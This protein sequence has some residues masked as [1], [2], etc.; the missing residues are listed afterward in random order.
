MVIIMK[1]ILFLVM[2]AA[3][4]LG[5][6]LFASCNKNKGDV[7]NVTTTEGGGD[8]GE[9]PALPDTVIEAEELLKYA[10][11]R[12]DDAT[13]SEKI[14][15]NSFVEELKETIGA[16]I[17]SKSDFLFPGEPASEFEI[18]FGETIREES[19]EAY[20]DIKY[21]DYVIAVKGSKIVI[22][23][24]SDE[25]L[26]EASYKFLSFINGGKLTIPASSY[27]YKAEYKYPEMKLD[28]VPV[29]EYD[30]IYAGTKNME[31]ANLIRKTIGNVSG[32]R[33]DLLAH[34][35]NEQTDREIVVGDTNRYKYGDM[36]FCSY[37]VFTN[38]K[39]IYLG[40][41]DYYAIKEA[42]YVMAEK[43]ETVG[44]EISLEDVCVSYELPKY[45]E[46]IEDIDKLYM[47]WGRE[48]QPDPA[49][50]DYNAKLDAFRNVSNRLLTCAHRA[51]C[52]YYPE[53]SIESIISF[54]KMGGDVVELDIQAT[55][56]G[57]LILMHDS[58]L[59]RMTNCEDFMG[60]TL[61]GID[62]PETNAVSDW[63]YEQIQYLNLKDGAG[64]STAVTPFKVPT[65]TEALKVC[66][67]RLLIIPDKTNCWSY[68]PDNSGK[69]DL[70]SCMKE[71][72][73]YESIIISYGLNDYPSGAMDIQKYIYDASGVRPFMLV[74]SNSNP[75][76]NVYNK[77]VELG[78]VKGSYGVQ[79][80]GR[81][82]SESFPERYKATYDTLRGKVLMWGW[83]ISD[84]SNGYSDAN[85]SADNWQMM[86]DLGYRM[87]M[88]NKY[89]DMVKFAAK[90]SG[91]N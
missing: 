47:R 27:E 19:A 14:L 1:K 38:D 22:A 45:S 70:F 85:D 75:V 61:F 81:F 66:K 69:S 58:T 29:S 7:G 51:E 68:L 35:K 77:F 13:S 9:A 33:L 60:K 91:F 25:S 26:E 82:D 23:G 42:A 10:V 46:Y 41:Y 6:C 28:G 8:I 43:I 48:W 64:G 83:T 50:L 11:V 37:K 40:G 71:A 5:V 80:N 3:L 2:V 57:V 88:T 36:P 90:V 79:V 67:N 76:N 24:G 86:Y 30:L 18:L 21:N 53:N 31:I 54:Y 62:F 84:A 55:A 89:L 16:D 87:I 73:N 56:D 20:K 78:A 63:T 12:F 72:N 4:L 34:N 32:A 17:T 65:L 15:F 44:A 52:T 39:S 49:M 74:R 59:K